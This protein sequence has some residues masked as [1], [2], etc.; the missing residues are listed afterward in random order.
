M[1][2]ISPQVKAQLELEPQLCARS[3]DGNCDGKITWEH[4]LIYGGNR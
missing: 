3:K 2:K 1:R 4:T